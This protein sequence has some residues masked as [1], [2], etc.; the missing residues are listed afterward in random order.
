M[1][2]ADGA[3]GL[4]SLRSPSPLSYQI[5]LHPPTP[6]D[7]V[8]LAAPRVRATDADPPRPA[9]AAV[10]PLPLH[11]LRCR[12]LLQ[13]P[14][15]ATHFLAV[16]LRRRIVR[17]RNSPPAGFFRSSPDRR[18]AAVPTPRVSWSRVF[19]QC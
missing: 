15:P 13:R 10:L 16:P 11:P 2:E 7:A 17:N 19:P 18:Q 6:P 9:P 5:H 1:T 12:L 4:L 14:N 8:L 3:N